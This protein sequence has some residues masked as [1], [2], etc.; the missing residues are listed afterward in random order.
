MIMIYAHMN[1]ERE[2]YKVDRMKE[3]ANST[4]KLMAFGNNFHAKMVQGKWQW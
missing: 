2:Q 1:Y 4:G 3:E